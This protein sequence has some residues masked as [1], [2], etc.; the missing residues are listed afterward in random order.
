MGSALKRASLTRL[1]G[2]VL[3]N[4]NTS[5]PIL[6][7]ES[8][9]RFKALQQQGIQLF[10]TVRTGI[11]RTTPRISPI[12]RSIGDPS[13]CKSVVIPLNRQVSDR[14]ETKSGSETWVTNKLLHKSARSVTN[15]FGNSRAYEDLT[16]TVLPSRRPA[17]HLRDS[18]MPAG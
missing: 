5:M 7:A 10:C 8:L 18:K 13:V 11:G 2:A 9:K 16:I 6:V 14:V 3:V 15:H 17:S 4:C 1:Q 12:A